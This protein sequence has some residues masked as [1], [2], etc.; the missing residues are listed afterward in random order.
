ML[1]KHFTPFSVQDIMNNKPT[2]IP[3]VPVNFAK[4][5]QGKH[6]WYGR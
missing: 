5:K 6:G 1:S 3:G 4:M 2:P